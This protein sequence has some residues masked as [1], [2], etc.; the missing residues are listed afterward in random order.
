MHKYL[1]GKCVG[2]DK[3]DKIPI[4]EGCRGQDKRSARSGGSCN[5]K[6]AYTTTIRMHANHFGSATG[7][8]IS[9][10]NERSIKYPS[11]ETRN[12]IIRGSVGNWRVG[13]GV[14]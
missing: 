9:G 8:G 4:D 2:V 7:T 1:C 5:I 13:H 12:T 3:V 10:E 14:G 6:G 11:I